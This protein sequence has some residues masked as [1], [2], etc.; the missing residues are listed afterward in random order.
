VDTFARYGSFGLTT[1]ITNPAGQYSVD[2]APRYT[3]D[4]AIPPLKGVSIPSV[5]DYPYTPPNNVNTGLAITWGVDSKIKTPYTLAYDLSLQRQLPHSFSVEADYVGTF[6]RHLLQQIDL[7]EPL[8]LVDPQSGMDYF[9]A[10]AMLA[11]ATYA[12]ATTVQPIAYWEDM[13]PYLKVGGMSATQNIYSNVYQGNAAVGNDSYALAVLDAF[14]DPSEGGLG[15]GPYED[16][17][18]NVKTRYYQRQFS[19]LYAWSSIGTSSYNGVQLTARKQST[20]G[21]DMD[22]SYTISKSIDMG[23]DAERASEFTTNSF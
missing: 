21:L 11:K 7:A 6:G 2:D 18:G 9:T 10:G 8:D 4:T 14:C 20:N 3:S 12:G 5:I 23:S 17:N 13:F 22:F 1:S 19:S 16:A 15:C